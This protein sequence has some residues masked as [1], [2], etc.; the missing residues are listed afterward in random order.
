MKKRVWIILATF[1][2]VGCSS[3]PE[4]YKITIDVAPNKSNGKEWDLMGGS[5]DIKVLVDKQPLGVS[6]SCMDTYRCSYTFSSTNDEW[7]I[8]VY[9]NDIDSDDLIGKGDCQEGEKCK[10]GMATVTISD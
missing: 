4:L 5:P 9:D 2:I 1:F 3:K 10:L 8:E 6:Q 7:Y